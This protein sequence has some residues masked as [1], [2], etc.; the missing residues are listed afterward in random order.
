MPTFSS[1]SPGWHDWLLGKAINEA[2]F[3]P[4]AIG[5]GKGG[6]RTSPLIGN[7]TTTDKSK[8][9]SM[10]V[11]LKQH[12]KVLLTCRRFSNKFVASD[13]LFIF[14]KAELDLFLV[15]GFNFLCLSSSS[16]PKQEVQ[17]ISPK[18]PLNLFR[19]PLVRMSAGIR[20]RGDRCNV[21]EDFLMD[22]TMIARSSSM[23]VI[24]ASY[25][26]FA[27]VTWDTV[28]V[29]DWGSSLDAAL[30]GMEAKMIANLHDQHHQ[31]PRLWRLSGNYFTSDISIEL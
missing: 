8:H 18:A 5:T 15:D 7:I 27:S 17:R 23:F 10:E 21:L 24:K 6:V 31:R 16:C 30:V 28:L 19:S 20:G 14:N 25:K 29:L 26:D 1:V 3:E 13:L 4:T 12:P 9:Q 2:P 11:T 22:S